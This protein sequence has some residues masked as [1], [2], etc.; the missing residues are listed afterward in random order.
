MEHIRSLAGTHFDPKA[1]ELLFQVVLE[2]K[3]EPRH[4]DG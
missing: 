3:K 1:V 4:G 2:R